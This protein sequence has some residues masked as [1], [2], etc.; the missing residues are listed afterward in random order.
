MKFLLTLLVMLIG[1][2]AVAG[3]GLIL[4]IKDSKGKTDYRESRLA[5]LFVKAGESA[6]PFLEAGKFTASFKGKLALKER[7]RVYFK[8][9]GRGKAVLKIAGEVAVEAEGDDLSTVVSKRMRINQGDHDIELIYTSPDS[10]DAQVRLLWMGRSFPWEPLG[11]NYT[12]TES[13]KKL[14]HSLSLRTGREAFAKFNCIKCHSEGELKADQVMPELLRDTPSLANAGNKFTESWLAAWI[15]NPESLR[16]SAT[17]PKILKHNSLKEAEA[18]GDSSASDLAAYLMTKKSGEIKF[19]KAGA[20]AVK[21]G[22]DLFNN[23]GCVSCHTRPDKKADDK[24]TPLHNI[25]WK[26][27]STEAVSQFLKNPAKHYKWI[28]MPD[29]GLSDKEASELA[30]YLMSGKAEKQSTKKG[31]PAKGEKLYKELGC[32]SCHEPKTAGIGKSLADISKSSLEGCLEGKNIK[33]TLTDAEKSGMKLLLKENKNSLLKKSLAEF[34]ERQIREVNCTACHQ[35]DDKVS[36][37]SKFQHETA[38][39]KAH[40]GSHLDQSRPVLTW[41]GEK[42]QPDYLQKIIA[43]DVDQRP[44]PWLDARM[45]A[46]KERSK[47][48]AQGLAASHGLS[49]EFEESPKA[50]KD[51]EAI[52]KKLTG[53]QGG[54]SC[55]ICHDAGPKKALAAFEVKGIDLMLVRERMRPAYYLRWMID[56][57]RI[58]PHTKMPKFSNEGVTALSSELEGDAVKQF[59][60]IYEFLKQGRKM[61]AVK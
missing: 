55:I 15:Q 35:Y 1:S 25:A 34:G 40:E 17:M 58:V 44:R 49:G 39:L 42:L 12:K 10:G 56:P 50:E 57:P 13:S 53:T 31:D 47:L 7:S 37:W 41:I 61:E 33:F 26:F 46:F 2:A 3:D 38:D 5:A 27:S 20:D 29:F 4:E 52:G 6:S 30:A 45:P 43:G 16:H 51:Y 9:E 19:A 23:L 11:P 60:A 8:I 59:W 28:K 14:A 22:G 32:A 18:A 24:R 48:L 36:D 21:N 54:F